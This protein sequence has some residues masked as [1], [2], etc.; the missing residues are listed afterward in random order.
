MNPIKIFSQVSSDYSFN[1]NNRV[2][3]INKI[4]LDN[5]P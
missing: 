5:D 4:I 3:T 1:S 2:I